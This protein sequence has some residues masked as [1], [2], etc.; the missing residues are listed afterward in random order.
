MESKDCRFTIGYTYYN[1]PDLLKK[2]IE[3]W[4]NFPHQVEIIL[5]DD[6]S[7]IFPAEDYLKD[8]DYPNFQL[9]KVDK[10][11]GFNSHGCR[12]LIANL[13][14]TDT[15]LFMDIDCFISPEN[16]AFLKKVNF[17]SDSVYK[18]NLFNSSHISWHS[19]PGHHNVFIVNKHKF[20]EAGGYDESFT[21]WHKGDREFLERL[22]KVTKLK[23]ISESLGITLLRGA[24][25]V[26]IDPKVTITTYDDEHM[27]LKLPRKP[28]SQKEL[29]GKITTKINFSYSRLL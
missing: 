4:N 8:F 6:G 15:V 11:L 21:G 16:V 14:S 28:P 29:A 24:R 17:K 25:K 23:K 19:F 22:E 10:D 2:Q 12:N 20:W 7:C 3:N 9:W 1:E 27:I 18:F 26:E 13:A 5:I